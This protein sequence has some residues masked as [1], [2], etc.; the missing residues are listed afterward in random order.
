MKRTES[1][2]SSLG[3]PPLPAP[4]PDRL[5]DV[6]LRAAEVLYQALEG[7]G[8]LGSSR[9]QTDALGARPPSGIDYHD[10]LWVTWLN[11]LQRL[12]EA[13]HPP[14]G[15]ANLGEHKRCSPETARA[16]VRS[17]ESRRNNRLVP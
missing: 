6:L 7:L 5:E 11:V 12:S 13:G 10:L 3:S 1:C 15:W 17:D 4:P 8:E 2:G 9:F 14:R 16:V